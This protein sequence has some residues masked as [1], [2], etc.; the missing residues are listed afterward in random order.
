MNISELNEAI[1]KQ[2]ESEKKEFEFDIREYPLQ[3]LQSQ[4]NPP[5][6]SGKEADLYIP[7]YQREFVWT[8]KQQS[9][10]IESLLIGLPVPYIF[11]A[12]ISDNEDSGDGR[13]EIIDGAQR[14]QTIDAF[15]TNQL[16]LRDM[17]KIPLLNGKTFKDLT[18]SRQRR[19]LRTTIR[20]IELQNINEDGRRMMFDRLNTGG[21][22]LTDMEKRRGVADSKF[23]QFI[24]NLAKEPLII[25]LTPLAQTKL[26]RREREEYVLRF[27]AYLFNYQN[28][29]KSVQGFLADF[30]EKI[31]PEFTHREKELYDIIMKTFK[32]VQNNF[33]C[34][35]KRSKSV[36][37]VSR[38]RFEAISVGIALAIQENPTIAIMNNININWAFEEEFLTMIRSDASNSKPKVIT[39][40]EYVK[41][42]IL[43]V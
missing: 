8:E 4:F 14:I 13:V 3:F 1:E 28:F 21:S 39:R 35:F 40:I 31:E 19:F 38:V 7:D 27:F 37:N 36:S 34:G 33:E 12:D 43:G 20:M 6:G 32:F 11:G 24:D 10:F 23:L 18:Q 15:I 22:K 26:S 2:I 16:I 5:V 25:E 29:N 42:K 17:E 9:L 30:I 41:N